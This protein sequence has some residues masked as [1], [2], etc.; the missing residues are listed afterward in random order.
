[1]T[2]NQVIYHILRDITILHDLI[3]SVNIP[4]DPHGNFLLFSWLCA[5]ILILASHKSWY[6]PMIRVN[7]LPPRTYTLTGAAYQVL[8][9]I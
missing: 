8:E 3:F 1:M 9:Y 4:S 7:F 6:I 2:E 5:L